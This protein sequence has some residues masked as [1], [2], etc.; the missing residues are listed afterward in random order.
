MAV[1]PPDLSAVTA[2]L[3][4]SQ[5]LR[6]LVVGLLVLVL[7]VPIEL[8][9]RQ[10]GARRATRDEAVAD[11]TR[12]WGGEQRLLGPVLR[13]PWRELRVTRTERG[14]RF[15]DS[16]IR[17]AYFLPESLALRADAHAET[18]YRGIFEV[19]LYRADLALEGR[20]R[21]PDFREW[22]VEPDAVLWEKAELLLAIQDPGALRSQP[23]LTWLDTPLDFEPGGASLADGPPS[24]RARLPAERVRAGGTF[25]VEVRLNG[26]RALAFTPVGETST[27][28][29]ASN[30]PHPSFQGRWLPSERRIDAEGFEA[31][32]EVSHL[33]RGYPQQWRDV[34][35]TAAALRSAVVGVDFLAPVD[36]Y[37]MA[38]RSVKYEVLF[39][40]L[41][42]LVIWLFEVLV[43]LR[44]HPIQY[45]F[46]GGAL[47]LFYLL[48][49]SLAE[50]LGFPVAYG[51]AGVAIASMVTL[52]GRAILGA[53]RRA[54]AL[55]GLVSALY[56]FLYVLLQEQD[57]ALLLGSL[58]LFGGLGLAMWVTRRVDWYRLEQ[59][60]PPGAEPA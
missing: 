57:Y 10:I 34:E 58:G 50:H 28:S 15:E 37:R 21:A 5:L 36:P 60:R 41:P 59:G 29:L 14:A 4:R 7:Q 39:L 1:S 16:V 13:V 46:V 26:A 19:P 2:A 42:F 24:L 27:V 12:R 32:W 17:H 33:A 3:G 55:G 22:D 52:Y 25:R 49:L 6:V 56:A 43:G 47:C 44:V 45:L 38:E 30:W 40:G 18:R 11:V 23:K 9:D 51:L 35:V 8:I 48:Q 31:R 20:F 54:A 53:G